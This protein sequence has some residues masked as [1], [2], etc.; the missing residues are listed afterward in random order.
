MDARYFADWKIGDRI[1][2]LATLDL[3]MFRST[4]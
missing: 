2:T 3:S 1:E 4:L